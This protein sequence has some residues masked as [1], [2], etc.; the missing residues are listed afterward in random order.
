MYKILVADDEVEIVEILTIYLEKDGYETVIAYDGLQALQILQSQEIDLAIIDI[1]MPKLG[2]FQLLKKVRENSSIPILILSARVQDND[3][4]LGLG[5]GADDY[6]TKPFNPM[7]ICARV[8]VNLNRAYGMQQ[9]QKSKEK[10]IKLYDLELNEKECTLLKAGKMIEITVTEFRILKLF[11]N[12]PGQVFTKQEIYEAGW[13]DTVV[14]DDNSIMV[15]IS[16]LRGKI[17]EE[18]IRTIRGLGYRMERE[19]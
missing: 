10:N 4:L 17:G 19:N 7:E 11:M 1:M 13:E 9:T 2:G 8:S 16:K 15:Y 6:I 12:H 14:V 5:L 3:K 18:R